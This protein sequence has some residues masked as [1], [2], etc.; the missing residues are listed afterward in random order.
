MSIHFIQLSVIN[1][2]KIATTTTRES[3]QKDDEQDRENGL[4]VLMI[5]LHLN[6]KL[7]TSN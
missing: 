7:S 1:S 6:P 5:W 3:S 4:K 2:D